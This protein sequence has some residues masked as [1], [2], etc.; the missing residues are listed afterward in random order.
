M[1]QAEILILGNAA[2]IE[3][4]LPRA[5]TE[6]GARVIQVSTATDLRTQ[7]S[8]QLPDFILFDL[9]RPGAGAFALCAELKKSKPTSNIPVMILSA[10]R[11]VMDKVRAFESGCADYLQKPF[12]LAEAKVRIAHHLALSRSQKELER[13]KA[14]LQKKYERLAGP[15]AEKD[16]LKA[17]RCDQLAGTTLDGK[18]LLEAKLGSGGFGTVYRGQQLSLGR[19]VAIKVLRIEKFDDAPVQLER[20]RREGVSTGRV[21]HRNAI[22][23]IDIAVSDGGIPYLVMELLSG[24]TLQDEVNRGALPLSRCMEVIVPVCEAL[25]AAHASGVIHRDIKPDNVFLHQSPQGEIVKVLDFGLAMLRD[26]DDA[27]LTALT[28]PEFVVGTALFLAPERVRGKPGIDGRVDVYSVAVM[29][30]LM[31]TGERPFP[32]EVDDVLKMLMAQL[33]EP[34]IPLRERRPEFSP[35]LESAVMAGFAKKPAQRPTMTEFLRS[36]RAAVES[37]AKRS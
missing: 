33:Q 5:L 4:R 26:A 16:L 7:L 14:A 35:A 13:E 29:L 32:A 25:A 1:M 36:L 31:L 15:V 23:V 6:L 10:S 34:P 3:R 17:S 11:D 9:E 30:Y 19:K 2:T 20:F 18:Y 27:P 21:R 37:D 8:R 12:D 24:Q 22:E 28:R